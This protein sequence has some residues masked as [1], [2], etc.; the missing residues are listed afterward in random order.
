V[1]VRWLRSST[2]I[3]ALIECVLDPA[4]PGLRQ[5]PASSRVVVGV[6]LTDPAGRVLA[7]RRPT[8]GWELPGGKVEPGESEPA[9]AVRECAEELGVRV[10]VDA[11]L[12]GSQP[13]GAG[14]LLRVW[15]GRILA[16]TPQRREHAELRWVAHDE[17]AGL[18]WLPADRPFVR[19]LAERLGAE[20]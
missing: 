2:V 3:S 15:T 16:G 9:A 7:A 5:A 1:G 6:A 17:L 8:G 10:E 12:P 11:R 14:Y 4:A 18:A 13:C 19:L 20:R